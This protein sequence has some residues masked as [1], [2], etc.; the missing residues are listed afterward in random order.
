MAVLGRT[1][2]LE[3]EL[4]KSV[5]AVRDTWGGM[6]VDEGRGGGGAALHPQGW[7]AR[8]RR[9]IDD[10]EREVE[11]LVEMEQVIALPEMIGP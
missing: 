5:K 11:S 7:K 2:R 3:E 1:Y 8:L 4:R 9:E 10:V 6:L